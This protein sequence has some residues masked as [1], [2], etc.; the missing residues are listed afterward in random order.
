M[1]LTRS[2]VVLTIILTASSL[3]GQIVA[4]TNGK[5]AVLFSCAILF[6]ILSIFAGGGLTS[7]FGFLNA[8]LIGKFLLV[9]VALKSIMGEPTDGPLRSPFT[10]GWV[11]AVGFFGVWLA[12][13]LQSQLRT[14]DSLLLGKTFSMQMLLCFSIAMVVTTYGGYLLSLSQDAQAGSTQ[15][16]GLVGIAHIMGSLKSLS[17]VPPMLYFWRTKSRLWMTHPVILLLLGW[18]ATVGVFSTGKQE[19]IEPLV[20]YVLVGFIRYGW[21]NTRLWS[22]VALGLVYYAVIIFPYSQYIRHNGGRA[23]SIQ[24]RVTA[25]K[26]AFLR[27]ATSSDFRSEEER[28]ESK[29][30]YFNASLS[31]FSRLAMVGEADRLIYATE[32][33]K[34]FTGW[35]TIT[36]GFKLLMP[37]FLYPNK[38]IHEAANYLSHIA[39]ES[40]IRDTTTQVSYGVMANFF[41]AF[42]LLGVAVG[43]PLFFAAFYYWIRIFLGNPRLDQAGGM[44]TLWFLWLVGLYQHRIVESTISGL[45]AS[46]S[47]PAVIILMLLATRVVYMLIVRTEVPDYEEFYAPGAAV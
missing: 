6:G 27:I 12:T 36:W 10:T 5:V 25:T 43:T 33:Q 47:F 22:L 24:D 42:A 40:N 13:A 28:K 9:A 15:T 1:V 8:I 34:A 11:M 39:G 7:I 16:G 17:I 32:Q 2:Q 14:P 44:S 41:N 45:I 38:P 30:Y 31:A 26:E 46:F 35:E 21:R 3:A 20:F 18:S 19:A 37:S 4:G 29:A 23:G